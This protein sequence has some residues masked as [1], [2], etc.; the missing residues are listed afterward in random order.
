MTSNRRRSASRVILS[1]LL[2]ACLHGTWAYFA[3][4][5]GAPGAGPRAALAQ[6][7]LSFLGT[8]MLASLIELFYRLGR[9]PARSTALGIALPTLIGFVVAVCTHLAAGT[10][11]IA[12]TVAPST[13]LGLIF[14]LSY[15]GGLRAASVRAAA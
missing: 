4:R 7:C 8:A 5:A 6:A 13:S 3:N 10:P 11:N 14:T 2:G 12:A 15:I 9:T 1:G